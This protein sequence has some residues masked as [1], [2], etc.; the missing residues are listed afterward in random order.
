MRS[1]SWCC[2]VGQLQ[3]EEG[4]WRGGQGGEKARCEMR[5]SQQSLLLR[6]TDWEV[7]DCWIAEEYLQI[8]TEEGRLWHRIRMDC[9]L[10]QLRVEGWAKAYQYSL[11]KCLSAF[12]PDLLQN[13]VAKGQE[14]AVQ[15]RTWETMC[16]SLCKEWGQLWDHNQAQQ[17]PSTIQFAC[18]VLESLDP[19]C[20]S[21]SFH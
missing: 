9:Y 20:Q 15:Q 1:C 11:K 21:T 5:L 12:T 10:R 3:R 6:A 17:L 19:A 13:Q 7:A 16:Q 18:Y 8:K 14:L 4:C 2:W